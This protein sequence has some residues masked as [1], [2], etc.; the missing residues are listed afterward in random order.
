MPFPPSDREVYKINPLNQVICQIRYPA[1]LKV[2]AETPFAFQE[3]VRAEYPVY[4][5]RAAVPGNIPQPIQDSLSELFAAMPFQVPATLREHHFFSEDRTRS[6]SLTTEFIAV[7]DNSYSHWEVFRS[8]IELAET[9]LRQVYQPAYYQRVGLRYVDMLDRD[10]IGMSDVSWQELLNPSLIGMLG[11]KSLGKHMQS[12]SAEALL[13]VSEVDEGFVRIKHGLATSPAST[14]Q[15][16]V[17]D[18]DFYTERRS[19]DAGAFHDVDIFH[20]LGGYL[21]RWA[22]QPRLRHALGRRAT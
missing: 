13:S 22:A 18:S 14:S 11:E 9:T 6:I 5:E 15:V 21:F 7:S 2:S 3:A 19:D 20:K 1:I 17:I 8:V 10:A 4:E 12:L 16:Y